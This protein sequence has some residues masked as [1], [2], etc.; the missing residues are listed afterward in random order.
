MKYIIMFIKHIEKIRFQN[1]QKFI[2]KRVDMIG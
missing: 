1:A 2:A